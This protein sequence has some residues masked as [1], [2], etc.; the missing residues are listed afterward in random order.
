MNLNHLKLFTFC[1][2]G[3]ICLGCN[4]RKNKDFESPSKLNNEWIIC[5]MYEKTIDNSLCSIAF[6]GKCYNAY[7][8]C[9]QIKGNFKYKETKGSITF[10]NSVSTELFCPENNNETLLLKVIDSARYIEESGNDL[11]I[12]NSEDKRIAKLIQE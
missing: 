12:L 1:I 9:N 3:F 4:E 10:S 8:G 7:A 11:Y 2:I 6:D 5:E